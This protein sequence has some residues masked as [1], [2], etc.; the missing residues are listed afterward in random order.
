MVTAIPTTT[1]FEITMNTQESGTPLTT[2]DGNSTSV[3]CYYTVGPA[4]QLGGYGW[5]TGLFGGT[6]LGAATTT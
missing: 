5:G 1:T 4:Q 2:S 6:A 3:L